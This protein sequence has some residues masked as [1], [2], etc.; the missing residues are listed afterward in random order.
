[1]P[2]DCENHNAAPMR[3]QLQ[4]GFK[5][6]SETVVHPGVLESRVEGAF[7]RGGGENTPGCGLAVTAAPLACRAQGSAGQCTQPSR[8]SR[9]VGMAR[10]FSQLPGKVHP[11]EAGQSS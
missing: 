7:V 3:P 9:D 10:V 2:E 6:Q 8:Q 4:P 1:M 5:R 11:R